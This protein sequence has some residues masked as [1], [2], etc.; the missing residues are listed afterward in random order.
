MS[1][2]DLDPK[3][4]ISSAAVASP[5]LEESQ[6]DSSPQNNSAQQGAASAAAAGPSTGVYGRAP[7]AEKAQYIDPHGDYFKPWLQSYSRGVPE[8]VDTKPCENLIELFEASAQ[9]YSS[10]GAFVNMG[11]TMTYQELDT[12]AHRFAAFLQCKLGLGPGD[13]I[14]I[15]LPNLLQF[16]VAFYGA[17]CA[18]LTVTNINPLYTPREL[19]AQLDNSDATAIVVIA[20]FAHNLAQIVERTKIQHVIITEIGDCL[21]GFMNTKRLLVNA[22]VRYKGMVTKFDH[23]VFKHEY[24]WMQAL[25]E[26]K[27]LLAQFK[28]PEVH[29]DD[30]AL[31][32][33]TGGTTG[34][35]KG[36]MLSHGNIIANIA[37][38]LGMYSQV[39]KLGQETILTVIPLYHIF[40][41]TV[42]MVLFTYL[43]GKN[44]LI[45]DPRN[46]KSFAQDLR[47]HPEISCMTGVNTLFNLFNTHEEF[48]DI[49]WEN[50]HLV[51]GGGAAVQSGVEERFYRKTGFHILEGY[52]LTECSPLCSVCPFDVEGY[53]GSIGLIVPSTIARIVD[54]EGNEIRD[55]DNEGELEIKGPQ[56]MHGYYKS[57]DNNE[58]FDDG[59]VRTGDVAKWLPGG[60]IKLIDRL[61]DMILVSGFN[62]FPNEIE[63]VISRF[64]RVLECAV[65]GISSEHTGEAVKVYAVK[66]DPSLTG[67]ELK[68][69]CRAYLTP[70]KVPRVIQF[71][72]SLPKS[73]LG[74]VL[75][76]KL[77]D[78][79]KKNNL[80]AE[81]QLLLLKAGFDP[82]AD[83]AKAKLEQLKAQQEQSKKEADAATPSSAAAT[84]QEA[85]HA[86]S[87]EK[88]AKKKSAGALALERLLSSHQDG[89]DAAIETPNI[90]RKLAVTKLVTD[91]ASRE[92]LTSNKAKP[93][94]H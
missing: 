67:N 2:Q 62:V 68:Q 14:A 73:A 91:D 83:D 27:K 63:D 59:Y 90:H 58:I 82:N 13:K 66:R 80:N 64:N 78:L 26:G 39:L 8:F 43:G 18:G 65:V 47:S 84:S 69:Y 20:N 12:L 21:G 9:K 38:A 72:D 71:V 61:K 24:K 10:H 36:A 79:D 6:K 81:D 19:Q 28:R 49:K 46:L 52:G 56:V 30:I 94:D 54:A 85:Q 60:Y 33:Y 88:G 76:R 51:I 50:L 16:P 45:T 11:K 42:N 29:Y 7:H 70:Y 41:L 74:K 35:S 32:Q 87:K 86:H 44:L 1:N 40:A 3:L 55:L 15:M 31:L 4:E 57:S 92:H 93:N 5:T 53:T 77:R 25:N 34:R 89:L 22:L 75:R 17:L 23:S 37:Q 48:K